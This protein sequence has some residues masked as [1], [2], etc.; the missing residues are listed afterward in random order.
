M[1]ARTWCAV[2]ILAVVASGCSSIDEP[3]LADEPA[4]TTTGLGSG[5]TEVIATPTTSTPAETADLLVPA[6]YESADALAADLSS[7]ELRIR[8]GEEVDD[9]DE[10]AHRQQRAYRQL[11]YNAAWHDEVLATVDPS[12]RT[13]VERNLDARLQFLGMQ[14]RFTDRMPDWTIIDPEPADA[15]LSYYQAAEAATGI[16]WEYLAAINLVETGMGR[17]SGV[18]SANAQGPMQFLPTTWEEQGIGAGDIW[19]PNDA[20]QAAARYLVRRGG[21]EDMERALWGYNNHDNYVAAVMDYADIMR[22]D[23]S[24]YDAF[25]AWQ[26]YF[27]TAQGDI[28]LPV[29]Y[30]RTDR[31]PV[32]QWLTEQPGYNVAAADGSLDHV[33]GGRRPADAPVAPGPC[34]AFGS[35]A[36]QRIGVYNPLTIDAATDIVLELGNETIIAP[37]GTRTV[38]ELPAGDLLQVG[39][40]ELAPG[41]AVEVVAPAGNMFA[42]EEMTLRSHAGLRPGD[43]L[44][45]VEATLGQPVLLVD[46]ASPGCAIWT[47]SSDP[48]APSL[49]FLWDGD[50]PRSAVLHRIDVTD[51]GVRTP[52]GISVG[53]SAED[54]RSTYGDRLEEL[55][56]EYLGPDASYTHFVPTSAEDAGFR[57][58]FEVSAGE[59]IAMWNATTDAAY[60]VEGCA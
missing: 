3:T 58:V 17:I 35:D 8:S 19:D 48:Y 55:P 21:P 46:D 51:A 9:L 31:L 32:T 22:D 26:I 15:L 20:I 18:S 16:E 49:Y 41:F 52:S 38:S 47:D 45:A 44:A 7:I 28:M 59:V 36:C 4:V 24:A 33:L 23:P 40:H 14:T 50:D 34:D 30:S 27:L 13:A 11:S 43:S 39:Y 5:V 57:L 6:P 1:R 25:H 12:I 56:H 42:A 2:A 10:I 37:G 60:L 53:A 29:G 54:L